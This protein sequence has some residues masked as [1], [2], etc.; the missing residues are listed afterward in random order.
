[1]GMSGQEPFLKMG[2]SSDVVN[3]SPYTGDLWSQLMSSGGFLQNF[4]DEGA[5]YA[6]MASAASDPM[7]F[8]NAFI[9][10]APQLQGI[11]TGA[12]SP[13]VDATMGVA[14][15]AAGN[16]VDQVL[17]RFSSDNALYSGAATETAVNEGARAQNSFVQQ[18]LGAQTNLANTL[19]G[20]GMNTL[21]NAF[22]NQGG[23]LAQLAGQQYGLGSNALGAAAGLAAPEYWQ[24]TYME[25]PDYL[26]SSDKVGMGISAA[27]LLASILMPK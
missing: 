10:L 14:N 6:S 20:G 24:P 17:N 19:L 22:A 23:L 5:N 8:M 11:A 4:L 18:A 21:S 7:A 9:G 16:A 13:F 3:T 12:T 15:T 27:N 1:M 25:N 2:D 26:S